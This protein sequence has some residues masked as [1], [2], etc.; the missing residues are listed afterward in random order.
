[1]QGGDDHLLHFTLPPSATDLRF[2]EGEPKARYRQVEGGFV[3]MVSFAPEE[4]SRQVLFSYD[5]PYQGPTLVLTR[6]V[7]Y[8]VA[9]LNVLLPLGPAHLSGPGLTF[10]GQ[11]TAPDTLFENFVASDLAPEEPIV[12]MLSNLPANGAKSVPKS[13]GNMLKIAMALLTIGAGVGVTA[14]L[15]YGRGTGGRGPHD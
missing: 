5:L 10:A 11:R 15:W 4:L 12:L 6:T 3:D 13:G 8:P 2:S 9:S 1:L 14:P 7:P